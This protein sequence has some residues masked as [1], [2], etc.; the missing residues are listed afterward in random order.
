MNRPNSNSDSRVNVP[1]SA[2]LKLEIGPT[3]NFLHFSTYFF[4]YLGPVYVR[5][6]HGQL[7]I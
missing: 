4:T 3:F 7:V 2:T 1:I 5:Q 6:N